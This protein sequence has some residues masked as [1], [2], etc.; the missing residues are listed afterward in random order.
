ME[1]V[2]IHQEIRDIKKELAKWRMK[3]KVT[4]IKYHYK[5][6]SFTSKQYEYCHRFRE[7]EVEK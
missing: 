3:L 1:D 7:K 2:K 5:I 4:I 6:M